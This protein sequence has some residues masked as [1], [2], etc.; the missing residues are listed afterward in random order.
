VLGQP[1]HDQI[2]AGLAAAET[3]VDRI[4]G[5]RAVPD[6]RPGTLPPRTRP[7]PACSG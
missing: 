7:C 4:T 1:G 5:H 2:A 3:M 6:G